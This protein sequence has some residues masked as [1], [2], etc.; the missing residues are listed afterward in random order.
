[1]HPKDGSMTWSQAP[2]HPE[3]FPEQT[4]EIREHAALDVIARMQRSTIHAD[5]LTCSVETAY[6]S[7]SG[8]HH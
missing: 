1:M 6:L 7:P 4:S 8:M 2:R 3:F 5:S